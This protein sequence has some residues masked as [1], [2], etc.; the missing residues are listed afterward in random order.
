MYT[1]MQKADLRTDMR[2]DAAVTQQCL[3]LQCTETRMQGEEH[4]DSG[5]DA[6][7]DVGVTVERAEQEAVQDHGACARGT[8]TT[9]PCHALASS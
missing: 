6:K 9:L 3:M 8:I 1:M 5:P 2:S 7:T 4:G